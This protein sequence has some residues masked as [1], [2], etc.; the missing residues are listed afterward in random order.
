VTGGDS[1]DGEAALDRAG[2]TE[3]AVAPAGRTEAG[4]APAG[5]TETGVEPA[6][7]R[8]RL[9]APAARR[10]PEAAGMAE[11]AKAAVAEVAQGRPAGRGRRRRA[12]TAAVG[13]VGIAVITGGVLFVTQTGGGGGEPAT[14]PLPPAT[15]KVTRQN[16]AETT[17][18]DGTLGYGDARKV[19]GSLPGVLTWLPAEGSTV[20]RGQALYRID[21]LP[22]VLLYGSMPPYRTLATGVSDG[23][24]VR[25][26]EENL[27]ALGYGGFTVDG[28]YTGATAAAVR[29][30]QEDLGLPQT[31]AVDAGRMVAAAGPVRVSA[32][33]AQVG[34]KSAAGQ[35]VISYTGTAR[36]VTVDL[37][38]SDQRLAVKGGQVTVELPDDTRVRGTVAAV[39]TVARLPVSDTGGSPAGG[40]TTTSTTKDATIEVTVTLDDP[41]GTGTLDQAPVDVELVSQRRQ[42][43]LAVPVAALL[44]LA[45]G[46]YGVQVVEGATTRIVAVEVGM[47]AGGRVEV[48]GTGITAG[49][50]VGVPAS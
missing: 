46:G 23:P 12:R 19:T 26:L 21:D 31:G 16:L 39:G 24:D 3:A 2:R 17:K 25:Q 8:G 4:V 34:D 14:G 1:R 11:A 29:Q 27:N 35:P 22:V 42:G 47:F 10:P 28:T 49:T 15:A 41:R 40:T 37:D 44:A 38:V 18:V 20:T 32:H 36:V 43:V 6:A 50:T 5:R 45:E 33:E 48:R 30:W 13:T 9:A 7:S